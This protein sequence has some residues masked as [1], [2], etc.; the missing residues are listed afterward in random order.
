MAVVAGR[1][2]GRPPTLT[3]EDV[4]RAA[5]EEGM[6]RLSMPAVA[7]RLGVSHSTLYRYVRDRDDLALAAIELA[8]RE[9]RWP[10]PEQPWRQLLVSFADA[11]WAFVAEYPGIA[12]T[13][14][15]T[16]GLP[17][18][19]V[20]LAARYA[21]NLCGSGL[22]PRDAVVAVDFVA[23]LTIATEIAMR[24]LDRT[25]A[26]PDGPATL[27]E[28]YQRTWTRLAAV[29]PT[30]V[31]DATFE[32]RGWF[33]DKLAIMLDGLA[34]R[35]REPV[36]AP[37]ARGGPGR[38]DRA[39]I[40]AVATAVARRDGL[41][42][43]TMRAVADELGKSP[44]ALYRHVGDRDG[45]IV[46]MLD[47]VAAGIAA[48]EP[49]DDPRTELVAIATAVRDALR[50]DPWAVPVLAAEG[51]AGPRILPLLDRMFRALAAAGVSPRDVAGA[52]SLIWNAVFGGLLAEAAGPAARRMVD[53]A[54]PRVFPGIAAVQ[55]A[56][57][58]PRAA[59]LGVEIA[60]DGVLS[61]LSRR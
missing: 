54:D 50:R 41:A 26:T 17:P 9:W 57:R 5:L 12:E 23:D 38:L 28:L 53:G 31:A 16:P 25:F 52:A 34:T 2:P 30:V 13:V 4:A 51:L 32:G 6:E 1:R 49:S 36:P 58:G 7:R 44:M 48:P 45:L 55:R 37:P 10:A 61:R 35:I 42:G 29:D 21:E 24:G 46:A 20:E 47:D 11:L 19:M 59:D 15:A 39:M 33:D 18:D 27:R 3:R 14:N 40:V 60:V 22:P 8:A 43:L 56:G